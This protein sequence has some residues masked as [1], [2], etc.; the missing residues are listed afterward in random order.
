MKV[1]A[2]ELGFYGEK[3][4]KPGQIGSVFTLKKASDFSP[5]WMRVVDAS[6]AE[7]SE[8]QKILQKR[9]EDLM[10]PAPKRIQVVED[11]F[12]HGATDGLDFND[13]EQFA[14]L[15]EEDKEAGNADKKR[16]GQQK[17]RKKRM[18][19]EG[20]ESPKD[21]SGVDGADDASVPA[22]EKIAKPAG[23]KSDEDEAL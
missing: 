11:G 15:F 16:E 4:R 2:I 6:S 7:K 17:A 21:F 1:K 18:E 8:L 9:Q 19:D 22:G 12:A 5:K 10:S 14:E 3:R 20:L 13:K 23:K